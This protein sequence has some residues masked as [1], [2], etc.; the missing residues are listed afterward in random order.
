M[1]LVPNTILSKLGPAAFCLS[2]FSALRI[3]VS[4]FGKRESSLLFGVGFLTPVDEDRLVVFDGL[5]LT[6]FS[7]LVVLFK[8]VSLQPVLGPYKAAF[9]VSFGGP[10]RGVHPGGI[11]QT[12][13]HSARLIFNRFMSIFLHIKCSSVHGGLFLQ[14]SLF[15]LLLF[16]C[17]LSPWQLYC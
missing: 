5:L 1:F 7:W 11:F 8:M 14:Y 17:L 4:G 3:Q 6:S 15:F 10:T 9:I 12:S 13:G 16:Q 2:V